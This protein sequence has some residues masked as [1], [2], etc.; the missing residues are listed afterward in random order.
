M[1]SK[2]T[3]HSKKLDDFK[4]IYNALYDGQTSF[5]KGKRRVYSSVDEIEHYI[6]SNPKSRTAKAWALTI[7]YYSTPM[8]TNYEQL[9]GDIHRYAYSKSSIFGL[10]KRTTNPSHIFEPIKFGQ[11]QKSYVKNSRTDKILGHVF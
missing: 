2:L 3:G 4:K 9:I 6:K 7:H 5:F 1:N 8:I 11:A 10:F